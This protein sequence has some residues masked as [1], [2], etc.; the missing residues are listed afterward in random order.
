LRGLLYALI[1]VDNAEHPH[2]EG[3]LNNPAEHCL[4]WCIAVCLH[5][6]YAWH[7]QA[8]KERD[9]Y[10]FHPWYQLLA[11]LQQLHSLGIPQSMLLRESHGLKQFTAL[12][13]LTLF[14][15][16]EGREEAPDGFYRRVETEPDNSELPVGALEQV[17]EVGQ[18][19][20]ELVVVGCHSSR[21][22]G[23]ALQRVVAPTCKVRQLRYPVL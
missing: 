12:T 4:I 21:L 5:T 19:L 3:W 8:E 1:C 13:S 23:R 2:F 7:P 15:G 9:V 17:A 6:Q 14:V 18:Q 22:M 11:P 20:Q 16:R 10:T